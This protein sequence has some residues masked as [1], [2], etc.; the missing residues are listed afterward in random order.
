[1]R[2]YKRRQRGKMGE[3]KILKDGNENKNKDNSCRDIRA[4]ETAFVWNAKP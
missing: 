4:Y 2:G 1:M 3:I